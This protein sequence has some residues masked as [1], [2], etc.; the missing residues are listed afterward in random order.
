MLDF[1]VQE[2][3]A[4]IPLLLHTA[5]LLTAIA[6]FISAQTLNSKAKACNLGVL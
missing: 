1:A 5:K 3:L 2:N 6:V 4:K